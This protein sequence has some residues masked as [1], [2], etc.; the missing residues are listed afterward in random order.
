MHLDDKTTRLRSILQAHGRVAV[1]FSGGTDS[2]LLAKCALD[3]LGAGNVLLLFGESALLPSREIDRVIHWSSRNGYPR[4]VAMVRLEVHPLRWKEFVVNAEDRCYSCKFRLYSLF[5]EQ[6]EKHGVSVLLDGTNTDDLKSHRPGLRAIH[7]L[8]VQTPLVQAGF[9]KA[10]VRQL[11]QQ[12]GLTDWDQPSASC[13]A[14]RI[15]CGMPIT[16]ER[17]R[18]IEQ[19]EEELRRFGFVGCR[20]RLENETG[21]R[22]CIQL[23]AADFAS[24]S[25]HTHRPAMVRFFHNHGVDTVLL[26]LV[27]R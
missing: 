6:L 16:V 12:L 23:R 13:L 24:F 19:W 2:S 11:S 22:V 18:Q 4:G 10:D 7:Q 1:A 9:D 20:V 15:P 17:L 8:G 14:T 5:R 26:D 3:T 21:S 27:G 25:M